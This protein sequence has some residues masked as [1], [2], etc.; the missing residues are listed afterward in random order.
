[1]TEKIDDMD[2]LMSILEASRH[3]TLFVCQGPPRC[4]L[5]GDAAILAQEADCPFCRKIHYDEDFNQTIEEPG[6]A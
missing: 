4:D 1:M 3:T 5:V 6:N 2:E